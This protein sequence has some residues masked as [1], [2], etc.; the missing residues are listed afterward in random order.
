MLKSYGV[1]GWV[2]GGLQEFS[3]SPVPLGLNCVLEP[4]GGLGIR[5]FG[6]GPDNKYKPS[7]INI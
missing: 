4:I 1:G 3:V 2:C 7:I 5:G 6:L